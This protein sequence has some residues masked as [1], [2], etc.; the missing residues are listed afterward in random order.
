MII[1]IPIKCL[2]VLWS[3]TKHAKYHET[4]LYFSQLIKPVV[5][6]SNQI[7]FVGMKGLQFQ[8]IGSACILLVKM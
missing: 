6:S 4:N 8:G 2:Q 7:D 3:S 1:N 5:T